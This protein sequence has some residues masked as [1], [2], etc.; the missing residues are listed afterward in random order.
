MKVEEALIIVEQALGQRYLTKIQE[1]VFQQ[2]W[3]GHSYTEISRITG[4]DPDYIKDIGSRLWQLLSEVFGEKVTKFNFQAVIKRSARCVTKEIEEPVN[5]KNQS[6]KLTTNNRI[7]WGEAPDVSTFYGREQELAVLEEWILQEECRLVAL[8]GVGG[9]G[10]TTLSIKL[11]NQV[12]DKFE[13][14]VWRSLRN[15]P[16]LNQI[17]AELIE[18]L[19][20]H[21]EVKIPVNS[22]DLVTHF[23]NYLRQYRCLLVLDNCESIL[24]KGVCAGE[25]RSGCEEYSYF[26]KC[27]G[28]TF[29]RSCVVLTSREKLNE[30]VQIE[31]SK[32]PV[33]SLRLDGLGEVEGYKV[34]VTKGYSGS[35]SKLNPLIK[36]CGGNPLALKVITTTLQDI[37]DNNVAEFLKQETILFGDIWKL[38]SEQFN[39]ISIVEAQVMYWL[40]IER[41]W[42]SFQELRA[43]IFPE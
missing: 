35:E 31:G 13:Y 29:H 19:S 6:F 7:D 12:K 21:Q 16:P 33:R 11:A 39:R 40:A 8:L 24:Q 42:T 25:Y 34:C 1:L 32:S 38:L 41:E 17:L 28:E 23:L 43:N 18:F 2:A 9:I 27:I 3:E 14:I 30:L 10:K 15:S 4:Y 36:R 20:N 37:F 22:N 26:L 5:K